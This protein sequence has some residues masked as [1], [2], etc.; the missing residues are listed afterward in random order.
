MLRP[1]ARPGWAAIRSPAALLRRSPRLPLQPPRR[2][3]NSAVSRSTEVTSPKVPGPAGHGPANWVS[4]GAKML[5]AAERQQVNG[6]CQRLFDKYGVEVAVVT[7]NDIRAL[8][9]TKFRGFFTQVFNAW[10]I[11]HPTVN[12]GLL[13]ALVLEKRRLEMV[14]GD[15]MRKV[16]TDDTLKALQ[17][18]EMVPLFRQGQMAEGLT[19]G[20]VAV[21]RKIWRS[22]LS[23]TITVPSGGAAA[24]QGAK[25]SGGG[26]KA[27]GRPTPRPTPQPTPQ[28]TPRPTTRV[29]RGEVLRQRRIQ[30][31][32]RHSAR[33][34]ANTSG[35]GGG[36]LG[37]VGGGGALVAGGAG[38]YFSRRKCPRCDERGGVT[39]TETSRVEAGCYKDG[40]T[41]NTLECSKC[42]HCDTNYRT[43]LPAGH[44]WSSRT[45]TIT[46]ATY[47]HGGEEETTKT[48]R[49]CG[50]TEVS[51]SSSPCFH[52][53]V[54]VVRLIAPGEP[55]DALH[56]EAFAACQQLFRRW[57]LGRLLLRRRLL[58]RLL[59]RRRRQLEL[60]GPQQQ[61]L[62][63]HLR[64][65][66][67]REGRAAQEVMRE[68][69]PRAPNEGLRMKGECC[70]LR[71]GRQRRGSPA[72]AP[73]RDDPPAP[74]N[75]R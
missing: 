30:G 39:V 66:G 14:T 44:D 49:R 8:Q 10:G 9:P 21:E 53:L 56:L 75:G 38:L 54:L 19:Q 1:L 67:G 18:R 36:G 6:V 12:N 42:G 64:R 50:K 59:L 43:T 27:S 55:P 2:G 20:M 74:A 73:A 62:R 22:S 46:S 58:G 4:D 63:D 51:V 70:L 26:T 24:R 37:L 57:L 68:E 28:P 69:R 52:V 65:R 11:G 31:L 5:S 47:S 71:A 33:G 45:R 61:P 13:V 72:P 32:A 16:L 3:I 60:G 23:S 17:Q 35:G 25:F 40:Y 29:T 34:G 7:L 15:G 48:C 41:V